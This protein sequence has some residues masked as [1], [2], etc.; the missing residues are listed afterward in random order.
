MYGRV[1]NWILVTLLLLHAIVTEAKIRDVKVPALNETQVLHSVNNTKTEN[2][3]KY[4][5]QLMNE[6]QKIQIKKTNKIEVQTPDTALVKEAE[7]AAADREKLQKTKTTKV[8]ANLKQ[9]ISAEEAG[10]PNSVDNNDLFKAKRSADLIPEKSIDDSLKI[11][12]LKRM[13]LNKMLVNSEKRMKPGND[14]DSD[15]EY[16]LQICKNYLKLE[17]KKFALEK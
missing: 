13:I 11:D 16:D 4:A 6:A 8:K 15:Y 17:S 3:A 14:G 2:K 1:K 10:L 9:K 5:N 12:A 7:L